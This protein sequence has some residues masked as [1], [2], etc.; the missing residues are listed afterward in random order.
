MEETKTLTAY[1]IFVQITELQKQLTENS[2]TSLHRLSDAIDS[3]GENESAE[4][5]AEQICDVCDV[6]KQRELTLQAML[7]FYIKVYNDL[8]NPTVKNK[9]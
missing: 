4:D 5:V 2:Y 7:D 6:F 1:D 3:I 8:Q 9:P